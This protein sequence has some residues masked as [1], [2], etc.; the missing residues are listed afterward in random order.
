M[1]LF[2]ISRE[3]KRNDKHT[4]HTKQGKQGKH[5]K[6]GK[7][8][9]NLHHYRK[10]GKQLHRVKMRGCLGCLAVYWCLGTLYQTKKEG[11]YELTKLAF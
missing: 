2:I 6:Q 5:P 7:Q 10:Q 8:T 9:V 4:I 11:A 1:R 3:G